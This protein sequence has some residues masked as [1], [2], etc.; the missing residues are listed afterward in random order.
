M[1]TAESRAFQSQFST[2]IS[3]IDNPL[4]TA[5][6]AYSRD[7]ISRDIVAK[8]L[9]STLTTKEKA[10]MLLTSVESRVSTNQQ[11]FHEFVRVLKTQT[12]LV[13]TAENLQMEYC[14]FHIIEEYFSLFC[15]DSSVFITLQG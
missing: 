6:E 4:T 2:L 10:A 8:M 13:Q 5:A 9:V 1:A 15:S 11:S 12:N 14:E 3:A 7:L